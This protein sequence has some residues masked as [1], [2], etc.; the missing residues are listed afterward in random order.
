MLKRILATVL[1]SMIVFSAGCDYINPLDP[2]IQLGVFWVQGEANKYYNSDQETM[3]RATKD[4]LHELDFVILEEWPEED[5]YWI[6]A[7]DMASLDSPDSHFKIKIREVKERL[8]KVSVRV[9][10]FGNKPYVEMLYRNIDRQPGVNQFVTLE[11]LNTAY[12]ERSRPTH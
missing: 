11:G 5:Y 12:T 1:A 4:T 9:N 8:T 3:I 10:V 7:S 2:I 6:K